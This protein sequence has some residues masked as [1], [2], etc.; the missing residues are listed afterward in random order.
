MIRDPSEII[1]KP[2][3]DRGGLWINFKN[4]ITDLYN[5]FFSKILSLRFLYWA[6][7]SD[8]PAELA[9]TVGAYL[10]SG[11]TTQTIRSKAGNA[12]LT[13]KNLPIFS[14]VY[15]P[16]I[17][18]ITGGNCSIYKGLIYY[19]SFIVG[20]SIIGSPALIGYVPF[21]A[22]TLAAK[23]KGAIYIDLGVSPTDDQIQ[24]ILLQL[25]D[26]IPVY[27]RVYFGVQTTIV[28]NVF[29]TGTSLIGGV[30]LIGGPASSVTIFSELFKVN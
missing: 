7:R 20:A 6:E 26:I 5:Y 28:S 10:A 21:G 13:H 8:F 30:D 23:Q 2:L 16:I 14:V 29:R 24:Q 19:G 18:S 15:K 1:P 27:F 17:D 9:Y 25:R 11:D 22:G 3:L 4:L 12:I